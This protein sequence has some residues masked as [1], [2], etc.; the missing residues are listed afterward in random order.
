MKKYIAIFRIKF[1]NTL[2]YRAAAIAGLLTQFAWGFMLIFA[3]HAFY[4]TDSSAFPMEFSETVSYIWLQ[5]A[6]L[7]LFA[8]WFYDNDITE[9]ISTGSIAYELVR[10]VDLYYRWFCQSAANRL[11]RALLRCAPILIVALIIPEPYRL[12]LPPDILQ[13]ALFLLSMTL[14]LGVVVA[15]GMLI[16]IFTIHTL[17]A[18]GVK[19]ISA[20]TSDF[21]AGAVIPLPFF[22]GIFGTVAALLPFASMQNMPLRIYSGNIAGAD[23]LYGILLQIFWLIALLMLGRIAMSKSLNKVIVQGG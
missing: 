1:I 23:A 12:S 20:V 7:A 15:F 16:Y 4:R 21:L 14:A 6:F 19:V 8:T 18:N 5:Q 17:S 9:S 3:F 13:F 11:A 10:P 22:P 2:Q